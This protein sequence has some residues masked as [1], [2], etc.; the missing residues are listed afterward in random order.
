MC[1]ICT[2]RNFDLCTWNFWEAGHGKGAADGIGGLVKRTCDRAVAMGKDVT[3]A[4]VF[5][6][7][8]NHQNINSFLSMEVKLTIW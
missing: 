1:E 2:N 5:L 8:I 4:E 6:N 3:D 7:T